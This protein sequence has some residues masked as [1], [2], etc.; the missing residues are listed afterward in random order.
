MIPAEKNQA[1]FKVITPS[2]ENI[3]VAIKNDVK[4]LNSAFWAVSVKSFKINP[5]SAAATSGVNT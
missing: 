2:K 4:S 3:N 1:G 5:K